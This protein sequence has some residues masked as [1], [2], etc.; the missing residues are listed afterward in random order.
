[1]RKKKTTVWKMRKVEMEKRS[2]SGI[3]RLW[4]YL[5][6]AYQERSS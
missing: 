5:G 2:E 1:M 6:G 4:D 3:H